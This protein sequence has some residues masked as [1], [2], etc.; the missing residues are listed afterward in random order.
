MSSTIRALRRAVLAALLVLA[1]GPVAGA[2]AASEPT[3]VSPTNGSATVNSAPSFSGTSNGTSEPVTLSIYAGPV[4]GGTPLLKEGPLTVTGGEWSL[5]A[6]LLGQGTYTAVASELNEAAELTLSP[7]VTF[8]ID[9]APV[10]TSNPTDEVVTAGEAA[11]FTASASGTPAPTVQWQ[12]S[13]DG[14][15]TW[16]NDTTDSG[17]T[18]ETLTLAATTGS[19]NGNE[20]RAV[21]TN[22]VESATSSAATLTVNEAPVV[23]T[24]PKSTTVV[25]P[26]AATFTAA[27]SGL[28]APSVQWQVSTDSGK[29]WT[30][31]TTDSGNTTGTLTISPTT[32]AENLHEYRAVFTNAVNTATSA[33]ATLTVETAPLVTTNPKNTTVVAPEP[34]SFKAAASG[35]PIPTVKW[36]S[37]TDGGKTWT[38]ISGATSD[39]LTIPATTLAES[40]NQ[41]R[42]VFKNPAG[43]A[44]SNPATLTVD[45][46]PVVTSNPASTSV[47]AGTN[48]TFTAAASGTPA[49]TVQWQVSINQGSTWTNDT[50]DA[51]NTTGTLTV[52]G[53]TVAENGHEYRAVF[54]NAAG[55][56]NSAAATLTVEEA[57]LVTS[58]PASTTAA[59]GKS[60][61]FTAAASGTPAPT[62]QWQVSTNEGSTWANDTTDAGNT[63]DTLKVASVTLSESG[64]EYRAVFTNTA[65]VATSTAATLA[66]DEKPAVTSNPTNAIVVVG[67]EA[68]FT[69]AASG[70]PAP[71][72]QWQVSTD[73]GSTWTNDTADAGNT[74]DTLTV[75]GATLLESGNEYRAVFTNTAGSAPSTAAT[76]T[77]DEKPAVTINPI[78]TTVKAGKSAT[79]TA[80]A[81]GVP[82]PTVQWQVST[83]EGSTWTNDTTDAGNTT[84]TLTIAATV[85]AEN[86][87]QYRAVFT[88]VVGS[89]TSTAATL[90]VET[91]PL[92]TTNPKS[93]NVLA[94]E[95]A[96]FT[97][98]ASGNP[99][100][101]VQWQ[102]STDG[103]KTWAN[104][105]T[106]SGD[107]TDTLT[108]AATTAAENGHEYRAVFTNTVGTATSEPATLTVETAPQV[109]TS[110][111]SITVVAPAAATFTA[112]ASGVPAPTVQWQVSTNGGSTWT[113]DTTDSG[114]TADTLIVATTA[115]ENEYQYRAVFTNAVGS[116]TSSA[117]TLTVETAP[118]VTTNPTSTSVTEGNEAT[119]TAAGSGRPAPTVQWQVSTDKGT[120]WTNDTTDG[121]NTTGTLTI[122]TTTFAENGNE[123]RAVFTNTHGTAFSTA[124]TLTVDTVPLVTTN[125]K[126]TTVVA[127]E[128][129]A[130]TS[131]ASGNPAPKPQ[132]QVST[133]GGKTWTND[134]TDSGNATVTLT[135][136]ATTAAENG[137]QYRAVFTN[138][139]GEK[140][141]GPATLTV[142]SAPAVTGN[143][144][145][146]S[147]QVG[148]DATFTVAAAGTPAPKVQWQVSTDGGNTWTNDTTDSGT[149]ERTLTVEGAT[150][151]ES[152]NE[153]RAV[154]TN[155]IGEKHEVKTA[156]SEGATL[157][158]GAP[159]VTANPVSE[160]VT[161]GQTATFTAAAVG[162]PPPEIQWQVSTDFGETWVNTGNTSDALTVASTTA[163][164]NGYEYR[165]VFTNELDEKTR[166]ATT[167][168]A[169]LTVSAPPPTPAPAATP[170]AP[171]SPPV[172]SFAWFPPAPHT[173]ETISLASS[174]TD[175][176]SPI[177]AFAWDVA[178]SG[179]FTAGAPVITTSFSTAGHHV[180][181]LRA[182]DANGL[183]G[184]VS[185][186]ITVTPQQLSLMQ[187]FPIVRIAGN[188]TSAGAKLSL[189]TVAAPVGSRITVTCKGRHCP[190][191][192]AAQLTVSSKRKI[193]V[194]LVT[195][196]TFE[197]SLLAGDVLLIRVW[198]PG[199]IGKYTSFSIHHGK[200]PTRVD[201][202]LDP[203]DSAPITCPS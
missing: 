89:V 72:V 144:H 184:M 156:T 102:L 73:S 167:A 105:T 143:P 175:A 155:E 30:N 116:A 1:V 158:V 179:V 79:F 74:T 103:G 180:V 11:T 13:K 60:A 120:T 41:Y 50:T 152:G 145:P 127:G 81:S 124:A 118:A 3:I 126:S 121:G 194:V 188:D 148:A 85:G 171:A 141:S 140:I 22:T 69:A 198:K 92:V 160:G 147:V 18:T 162:T 16:T 78:S 110:P 193:G 164:E 84:G 28:P 183:S 76:L 15:S 10:V 21:F 117:A 191:K 26:E 70:T 33:A 196:K 52:E 23:T 9:A 71:A 75:A 80:A 59:V 25:A 88:N 45:E 192:L 87:H 61:T 154:L 90:T 19:E 138:V 174:S 57:P 39:T 20:Y 12:V 93:T 8:T 200:L 123:Y 48:A 17:N 163:A 178:D 46:K 187:P 135:V 199:E 139:A 109:T 38:S 132:W 86:G 100:P 136:S 149:T 58:N 185:E 189:L 51:G 94:G 125:P 177:T 44:T 115:S 113:N 4:A 166:T 176:S 168:V 182:T 54:S 31:D 131:A 146:A 201:T 203:N 63:T 114:N 172:A 14:G 151:A 133:N 47:L 29:T 55:S 24:N 64:N 27:A 106:D 119:F 101:T 161:V 82:A 32:G 53:A 129:A 7:A 153:Y 157:T 190:A 99:A 202:C 49:P 34:A 173:G 181:S 6:P 137:Y 195:F 35:N 112:A 95:A 68:T 42:A 97:S 130:F 77:V 122:A 56:I 159:L 111:K 128:A 40:G 98:A 66:V 104:D 165:A 150:L 83:D 37:S 142:E 96:T 67:K 134:T 91:A 2:M 197:R 170:P 65:G 5:L 108:V 186:T 36:Q 62:V 43:S 107:T 169:T